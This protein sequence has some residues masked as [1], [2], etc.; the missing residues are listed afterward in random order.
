MYGKKDGNGKKDGVCY[1]Y[2][3]RDQT[4]MK[5]IFEQLEIKQE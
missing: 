3:I 2:L 4:R 5:G 1:F